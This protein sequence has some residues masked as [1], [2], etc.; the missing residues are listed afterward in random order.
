[1][2]LAAQSYDQGDQHV[3]SHHFID[4][5][6]QFVPCFALRRR[7][8]HL[9][10]GQAEVGQ[11]S[12]AG[13]ERNAGQ[14]IMPSKKFKPVGS[15]GLTLTLMLSRGM[16]DPRIAHLHDAFLK[17]ESDEQQAIEGIV[18]MLADHPR[19][20]AHVFGPVRAFELVGA[21]GE[22]LASRPLPMI[23]RM[24]D[25]IELEDVYG[26]EKGDQAGN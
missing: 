23:S 10:G 25:D 19:F 13:R 20:K 21:L 14:A 3:N 7:V 11:E 26:E 8:D 5:R 1:V 2:N 15:N 17:L 24:L 22:W 4:H 6:R 18:M 16:N 9:P 12:H